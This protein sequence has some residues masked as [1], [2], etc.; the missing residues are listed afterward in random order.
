MF[1]F[2]RFDV[3]LAHFRAF[4]FRAFFAD[5]KEATFVYILPK[6]YCVIKNCATNPCV[7]HRSNVNQRFHVFRGIFL[8]LFP[9]FKFSAILMFDKRNL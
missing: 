7:L 1:T 6:E 5:L 9:S 3:F 8:I 2:K 4:K